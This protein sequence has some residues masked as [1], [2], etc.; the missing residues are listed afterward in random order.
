MRLIADIFTRT[1]A[2]GERQDRA[3]RAGRF[4]R[5]HDG[6]WESEALGG[7]LSG[8]AAERMPPVTTAPV[9]GA[10]AD[11]LCVHFTGSRGDHSVW[12]AETQADVDADASAP[13]DGLALSW[14]RGPQGVM[15]GRVSVRGAAVVDVLMTARVTRPLGRRDLRKMGLSR[16]QAAILSQWAGRPALATFSC[17]PALLPEMQRRIHRALLASLSRW[18]CLRGAVTFTN[19]A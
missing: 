13:A 8:T 16:E 14:E 1:E 6:G 15:R 4:G 3:V 11:V 19:A 12:L 10:P 17:G 2:A 18:D 5:T 7:G 9:A